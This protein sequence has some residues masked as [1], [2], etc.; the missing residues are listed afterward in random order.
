METQQ[1]LAFV[2]DHHQAVLST[3]GPDGLPR[4][5][6]VNVGIDGQD[7]LVISSTEDRT[8]TRHL[9]RDPRIALCVLSDT[10]YGPWVQLEGDAEVVS[11][12]EAMEPLEDYYRALSGEHPN[13][14]EYR[15]AMER[16]RRVLIRVSVRRSF[17]VLNR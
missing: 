8:K 11:L 15:A 5:S 14:D 16:D 10:F 7:R 1:A 12:P 17:G 2:R 6:P 13:W 3:F 9:R 4:M